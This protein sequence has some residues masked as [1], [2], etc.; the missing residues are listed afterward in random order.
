VL[1]N[2]VPTIAAISDIFASHLPPFPTGTRRLLPWL[3]LVFAALLVV[4]L[5]LQPKLGIA[6]LGATVI[7][8]TA[9]ISVAIPL[10]LIGFAAPI[11]AVLGHDPFPSKAVPLITFAWLALAVAFALARG[12]RVSLR[13][14][15][16]TPLVLCTIGLLAL[17]LRPTL[18]PIVSHS[19][20]ETVPKQVRQVFVG[21]TA[22]HS[23]LEF[24]VHI[25]KH[26]V[27]LLGTIGPVSTSPLRHVVSP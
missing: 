16:S 9:S 11:V 17:L 21:R 7:C 4:P 1:P 6:L 8:L 2:D 10:G 27:E 20:H 3:T 13:A 26:L 5:T 24:D 18:L 15:V 19:R 14:A 12:T 22:Q 25:G 23:A